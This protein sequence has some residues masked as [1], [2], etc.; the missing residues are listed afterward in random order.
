MRNVPYRAVC[1]N[2]SLMV[3][4]EVMKPLGCGALLEEVGH[5]KGVLGVCSSTLLLAHSVCLLFVIDLSDPG[6]ALLLLCPPPRHYGLS[7]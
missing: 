5:S 1:L 6:S 4:G 2:T 7:F 3:F